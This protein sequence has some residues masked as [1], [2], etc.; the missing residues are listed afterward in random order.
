AEVHASASTRRWMW[1]FLAAFAVH[2][3][4]EALVIIR[5]GGMRAYG[6]WESTSQSLAGILFEF[7]LGWVLVLL[8]TRTARPGWAVRALAILLGG[9][10]L[11][12]LVHLATGITGDGYTFGVV[13]ALP[14][15]VVYGLLTLW[16]MYADRLLTRAE[17]LL[18]FGGG[19][20]VAAPLILIAHLFGR[21]AA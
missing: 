5:H 19:A 21:L 11:Y 16:R 13:T 4:E 14:A 10:T 17:I 1:G 12:G 7:A 3:G 9:W 20:V 18:A 6:H 15:A 8:A 2:D